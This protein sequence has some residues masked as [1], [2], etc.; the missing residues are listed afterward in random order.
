MQAA[1]HTTSPRAL[2]AAA[3]I[4][5]RLEYAA[6]IAAEHD[7]IRREEEIAAALR[8]H[9]PGWLL[10]GVD[11]PTSFELNV[12][13]AAD[14]FER[15]VTYK[16]ADWL[17]DELAGLASIEPML[18]ILSAPSDRVIEARNEYLKVLAEEYA[19]RE[20]MGLAEAGWTAHDVEVWTGVRHG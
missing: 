5:D 14:R 8:R 16:S 20:A 17:R 6:E 4:Y 2:E 10:A 12:G 3:E 13:D 18:Q 1:I 19:D 7:L 9:F 15:R 11:L